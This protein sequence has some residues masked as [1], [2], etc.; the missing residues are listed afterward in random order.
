M[1]GPSA[2]RKA[3]AAFLSITVLAVILGTAT[4]RDIAQRWLGYLRV[5][6]AQAVNVDLTSFVDP[7]ANP[8]LHQMVGQMISDKVNLTVSEDDQPVA[9]PQAATQRAGF[10]VQLI[11]ARKDTPQLVVSGQRAVTMTVDR[12]RLQEIVKAAGHPEI[13]L[14]TSLDGASVS[15]QI[16][17][18]LHARYGTCPGPTTAAD[19][20]AGQVVETPRSTGDFA[21]CIRFSEGPSPVVNIPSGLDVT[22]LAEIGLQVTGMTPAQATD[23][24][25]I[26]DWKSTLTLSVPRQLRSYEQ[27]QVAGVKGTLLTLGGR[28]GPGYTLV[29][30]KNGMVFTLTG[31]GDSG[32]AVELADSVK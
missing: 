3:W 21:D 31:Y 19:A 17:R 2:K 25:R 23:F 4:G 26:V 32:H 24:F 10:P 8:T 6:K 18:A 27:V 11:A 29:W 13:V 12:A 16:T 22:K 15:V 1:S 9:D 14:P 20:I 30:A 7:N 5:Q 28:R